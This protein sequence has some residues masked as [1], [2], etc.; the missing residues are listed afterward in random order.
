MTRTDSIFVFSWLASYPGYF[1][2]LFTLAC[3]SIGKRYFRRTGSMSLSSETLP[4][5][6]HEARTRQSFRISDGD[7]RFRTG[8]P[9]MSENGLNILLFRQPPLSSDACVLQALSFQ[10]QS[11]RQQ[12]VF[13]IKRVSDLNKLQ[14]AMAY[15]L[16]FIDNFCGLESN[17]GP[18]Q[19]SDLS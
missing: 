13:E 9:L 7:G 14:R 10:A 2:V 8:G 6:L 15:V 4:I 16:C 18:I 19:Q 12:P 3:L 5:V 1:G 11:K 17:Q